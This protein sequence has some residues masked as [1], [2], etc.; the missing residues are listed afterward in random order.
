M[1]CK[2]FYVGGVQYKVESLIVIYTGHLISQV[3]VVR[4]S[5]PTTRVH[6]H[7]HFLPSTRLCRLRRRRL[8]LPV[9]SRRRRF[10]ARRRRKYCTITR[11]RRRRRCSSHRKAA[12]FQPRRHLSA[13]TNST[14]KHS[15]HWR[16]ASRMNLSC[17]WRS[18]RSLIYQSMLP[19]L[20]CDFS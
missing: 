18:T 13:V 12:D 6:R 10:P 15:S 8:L 2:C 20:L 9:P 14:Q 17:Q 3:S 11:L 1:C 16:K 7:R 5:F 4:L 19:C